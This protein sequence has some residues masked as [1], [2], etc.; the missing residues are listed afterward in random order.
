MI[1]PTSVRGPR[2]RS[3]AVA[4]LFVMLVL[5]S[6]GACKSQKGKK[7]VSTKATVVATK[8]VEAKKQATPVPKATGGPLTAS[9]TYDKAGR[10]IRV[11]YSNGVVITY[12]YDKA[13][14]LL[15]REVT[16]P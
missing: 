13:G 8:T 6:L 9:Y 1:E 7:G 4:L 12:T 16:A 11:E 10:L 2:K 15:R 14:N 5:I 3:V